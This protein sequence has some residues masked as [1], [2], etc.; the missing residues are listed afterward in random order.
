MA[1]CGASVTLN[2]QKPAEALR[3]RLAALDGLDVRL[4]LGST[5]EGL[6]DADVLFASPGVPPNAAIIR[7]AR[8]RGVPISSETRLFTQSCGAPIVGITGSS[9]KTTTTSLV[10]R[11]LERAGRRV[12][13]GGNI[14]APLTERLLEGER[15]QVAV[16]ELSSFQLELFSP[17][18]QGPQVDAVRSQ[19]SRVV[20][21]EGW[22]PAVAAVTN[23]TPNHLDRH[24]SMEDYVQ[25]KANVLV[26]QRPSN[27]AVLNA[28]DTVTRDLAS[29]TAGEVLWFSLEGP[30]VQ[31]AYLRGAELLLRTGGGERLICRVGDVKLR[32]RHNLANILAAACCATAAGCDV[33]AVEEAATT[34]AG[35]SHRLEMVRELDGV[36]YINDS[37]ATSPERAIAALRAFDQPVLLLAGGRD[38]HLPWDAWADEVLQ[39]VHTVVAFGEAVPIIEE[40]LDAAKRRTDGAGGQGLAVLSAESLD[41]AVICAAECARA[42]TVVLL[43]PGGTSFDA[44]VDFEAR[45]QR[46]RELVM[47]L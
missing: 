37:I 27:W 6:L 29:R 5:P 41:Q 7:A 35:V 40:A 32:G 26:Y 8:A 9:G 13:V 47:A 10:G 42:G 3:G 30:V 46:F 39:R 14:G 12:W 24:P 28:D 43:S 2:D 17:A 19:G 15:P 25:A 11:M 45:G 38:K 16:M 21:L 23:V 22:S 31:G 36:L 18:Y 34:F 1:H 20:S 33:A 4:V 44:F